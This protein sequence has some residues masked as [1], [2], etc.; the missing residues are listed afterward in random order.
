MPISGGRAFQAEETANAKTPKW[1]P[2]TEKKPVLLGSSK[3]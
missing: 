2:K 3:I 1:D